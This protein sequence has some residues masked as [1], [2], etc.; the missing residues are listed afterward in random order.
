MRIRVR[1]STCAR[2][3]I[4]KISACCLSCLK[5]FSCYPFGMVRSRRYQQRKPSPTSHRARRI[6]PFSDRLKMCLGWRKCVSV[7]QPGHISSKRPSKN[8]TIETCLCAMLSF[9]KLRKTFFK[10]FFKIFKHF[11]AK[12]IARYFFKR[13]NV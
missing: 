1:S 2:P 8:T 4:E 11:R 6:R 3:I 9:R 12:K 5:H 13:E 10:S 7:D